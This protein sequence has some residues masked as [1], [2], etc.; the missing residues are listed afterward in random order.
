MR[1]RGA[2]TRLY[3]EV[4]KKDPRFSGVLGE[5]QVD[6][7]KGVDRPQ[8]HVSQVADG[9]RDDEQR[10]TVFR[11]QSGSQSRTPTLTP[12]LTPTPVP[13]LIP[14]SFSLLANRSASSRML[15]ELLLEHRP[16]HRAD[17]LIDDLAVLEEDHHRN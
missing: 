13:A 4:I 5:D 11:G 7:A 6:R 8:R 9:R 12:T 16:R 17:H 3:L 1:V 14:T 15:L 2:K 10:P